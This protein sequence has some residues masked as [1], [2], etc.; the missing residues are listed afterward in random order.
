MKSIISCLLFCSS[1]C[2]LIIEAPNLT[3]I[4][5]SLERVDLNTLVLFDVDQTLIKQKDR[6]LQPCK[7]NWDLWNVY[8]RKT[9][10]NRDLVPEG[11]YPKGY[12]R[13]RILSQMEFIE[14]DPHFQDLIATLKNRKIK[15][16]AF[17]RMNTGPYGPIPSMEDWRFNQL[18]QIGYD[19]T[20]SFP[21]LQLPMFKQGILYANKQDKGPVLLEFLDHIPKPTKIIFIDDRLDY[22]QSVETSLAG[23]GIE[24]TGFHYTAVEMSLEPADEAIVARQL[25]YLAKTS[26]WLSDEQAS[27][28]LPKM[29]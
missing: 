15:T 9:L 11:K 22:L 26:N 16:V 25:Y 29:L 7:A 21:E 13:A 3:P 19:F 23:T 10:E 28:Q 1:L 24:F 18:K 6:I 5:Q 27:K 14:V 17:T 12:L 20:F 4:E 8:A 2:A